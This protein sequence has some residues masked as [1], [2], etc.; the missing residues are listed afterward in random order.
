MNT[1]IYSENLAT[2]A[3][4]TTSQ[5]I[6]HANSMETGTEEVIRY[7]NTHNTS[8]STGY[9][10]LNTSLR[11]AF[12]NISA[13]SGRHSLSGGQVTHDKLGPMYNG[14]WI[15]QTETSR[16]FTDVNFGRSWTLV[17]GANGARSLRY[18]V[19]SASGTSGSS[20]FTIEAQGSSGTWTMHIG[21][22]KVNGTDSQG[23]DFACS[24]SS[25]TL[26]YWINVTEGNVDGTN[27]PNLHF[28][29]ELDSIDEIYYSNSGNITGSYRMIVNTSSVGTSYGSPPSEPYL[30]KGIYG[31]TIRIDFERENLAFRTDRRVITGADD[32]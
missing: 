12:E 5:P 3:D 13:V 30:E 6:L 25:I 18:N 28:A 7:I 11:R 4:S 23:T 16:N 20:A 1:V 21:N 19:H 29:E 2:R 14:T 17:T 15:R 31:A 32:D 27:C 9:T 24:T 22:D 10:A 8:Q 26:P